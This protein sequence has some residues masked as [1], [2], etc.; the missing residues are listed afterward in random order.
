MYQWKNFENRL[1]FGKDTDN[2][3]VKRFLRLSVV[4]DSDWV[5]RHG[6]HYEATTDVHLKLPSAVRLHRAH[7][8]H[9]YTR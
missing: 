2:H 8:T 6:H 9:R 7:F 4:L 1:I 5:E 3:K